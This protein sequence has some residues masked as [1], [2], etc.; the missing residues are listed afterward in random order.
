MDRGSREP[1]VRLELEE[2]CL[3]A[4]RK[5]GYD[6]SNYCFL[7]VVPPFIEE[8]IKK[9]VE[10]GAEQITV[11]PYFLYPGMKLKDTVKRTAQIIKEK[12]LKIAIA[13]PLSYHSM[14]AQ[15]VTE[16][17]TELKNERNV[18]YNDGECDV[19]LIGHG[20]TD[21]NAHDAFVFTAETIRPRYRQVHYCFLELD[22]P[23][24]EA[25]IATAIAGRPKVILMMPYFLHKGAHIK[26][27]VLQDINAALTKHDFN[28]AY[29][30]RHLGVDEKLVNLILERAS[31]VEERAGFKS[32]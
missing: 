16:R 9:C 31:E 20:S 27:D 22:S 32:Q 3:I 24:I 28:Q 8:G 18:G 13:R 14:M 6:A 26:R 23:N 4:R 12:K 30:S 15:L 17:I 2:I 11:M 21:K 5:A 19:L 29:L 7:E 25:G 1:E 10:S